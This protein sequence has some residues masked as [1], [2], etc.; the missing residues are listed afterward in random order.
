MTKRSGLLRII[1][2]SKKGYKLKSPKGLDTRPTQDRIKESLFSILGD[3]RIEAKVLDL[4]AGSGGIGIEFLSRGAGECYFID[5][6]LSSIKTINENLYETNLKS[7]SYVYKNDVFKA[8][9]ILG[10]KNIRFD[11]IFMDPPYEKG[12]VLET[13]KI[14]CENNILEDRGIIIAEHESKLMIDKSVFCL[15]EV[16]KRFYGDKAITFYMTKRN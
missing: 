15:N 3:I 5:N 13:L 14:V 7:K 16:D 12:L 10:K 4:F 11:Y 1:S 8:I 9:K 2:G 6:S